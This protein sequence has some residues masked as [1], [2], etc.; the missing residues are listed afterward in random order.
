[1]LLAITRPEEEK[2]LE[3]IFDA[4]HV[5]ILYQ[6]R[7]QG[8]APSELLDIFGLGGTTWLITIGLLPKFAVKELLERGGAALSS[9]SL[10]PGCRGLCCMC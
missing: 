10:S 2:K 4:V 8:T 9:P 6:C 1:M 5:P 3:A 7:G